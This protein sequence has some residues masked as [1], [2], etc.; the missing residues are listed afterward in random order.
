MQALKE[1]ETLDLLRHWGKS[2]DLAGK[3]EPYDAE[4]LFAAQALLLVA[5]VNADIADARDFDMLVR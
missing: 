2:Q 3:G 4:Q 1:A 5:L